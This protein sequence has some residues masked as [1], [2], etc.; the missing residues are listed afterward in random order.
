MSE[1]CADCAYLRSQLAAAER[2]REAYAG[3]MVNMQ[4]RDDRLLAENRL[5]LN[6]LDQY[7]A[8]LCAL[9]VAGVWFD[10]EQLAPL[11]AAEVER[12]KRLEAVVK[13]AKLVSENWS[14]DA[15]EFFPA[16]EALDAALAALEGE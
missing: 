8:R 10:C 3:V 9:N 16:H 5:L 6:W 13:A 1:I 7:S 15:R 12:V 11:T 14:C 2:E 4:I